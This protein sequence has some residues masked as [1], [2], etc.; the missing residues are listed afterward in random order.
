MA[1]GFVRRRV[2]P[3]WF[4]LAIVATVAV[5][6]P[7]ALAHWL[8]VEPLGLHKHVYGRGRVLDEAE[9]LTRLRS[10]QGKLLIEESRGHR[11]KGWWTP[12]RACAPGFHCITPGAE[13][14]SAG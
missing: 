9:C 10:G 3:L 7:L 13:S 6:L 2:S 8:I 14:H 4:P 5:C 1:S 12:D 11:S